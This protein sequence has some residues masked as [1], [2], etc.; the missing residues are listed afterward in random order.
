MKT[1]II[2]KIQIPEGVSCSISNGILACT[3]SGNEIKR[4]IIIP[5]ISVK[6]EGKEI[7]FLCNKGNKNDFKTIKSHL[8]HMRNIFQGLETRYIYELESCNVHFP[9]T[10]KVEKNHL[11]ITNFLGEKVPRTAEIL[12]N[13][14][15]QIKGPKI[16]VTSYN[17]EA[18]GQTAANLE[19]AT[20]VR[21]R[22]RRIF[23][24]GI[25]IVSKPG[26]EA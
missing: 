13:V 10:L 25:Y 8:A 2:E 7:V 14:D 19:K 12:P 3:K 9:M 24:D 17:K 20:I 18:A 22:D 1:K 16:T 26:R 4:N 21:N 15:I 11:I 6:I 23:Q 5:N